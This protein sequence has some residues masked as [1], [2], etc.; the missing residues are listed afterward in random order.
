MSMKKLALFANG[1]LI[2][3]ALKRVYDFEVMPY[4]YFKE[5]FEKVIIDGAI[6]L[7]YVIPMLIYVLSSLVKTDNKKLF[8]LN[9]TSILIVT[10]LIYLGF[11]EN[12]N[13]I[14]LALTETIY[15]IILTFLVVSKKIKLFAPPVFKDVL[16]VS[17][18]NSFQ[19]TIWLET[20]KNLFFFCTIWT[21]G[22]NLFESYF[23]LS[24]TFGLYVLI[25][26][27]LMIMVNSI[28]G[29]YKKNK[30]YLVLPGLVSVILFY[31]LFR[32]AYFEIPAFFNLF[33]GIYYYRKY[34]A[35]NNS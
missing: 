24:L 10:P 23:V 30:I 26:F 15:F 13:D 31:V 8:V 1:F 27:V 17:A 18:A 29:L 20:S 16:D 9:I 28:M 22:I 4:D 14:A 32:H 19:S 12:K 34:S 5:G 11:N 2:S 33:I 6:I 25:C 21:I 35:L 3:Y 7:F